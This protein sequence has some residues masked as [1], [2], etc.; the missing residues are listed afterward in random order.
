MVG[1]SAFADLKKRVSQSQP[2]LGATRIRQSLQTVLD[3]YVDDAEVEFT[4][5][6]HAAHRLVRRLVWDAEANTAWQQL[7][8]SLSVAQWRRTICR[9]A[10]D[11]SWQLRDSGRKHCSGR[12]DHAP[13]ILFLPGGRCSF[14][15]KVINHRHI[16]ATRYSLALDGRW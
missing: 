8:K 16:G 4:T 1:K 12:S 7:G 5:H 15:V 11:I 10:S 3:S 14:Q 6:H 2:T 13:R 9:S